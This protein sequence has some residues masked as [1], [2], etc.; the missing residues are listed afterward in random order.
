M[1]VTQNSHTTMGDSLS[2]FR[3]ISLYHHTGF[4]TFVSKII[5]FEHEDKKHYYDHSPLAWR[6][7]DRYGTE[8]CG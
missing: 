4:T 5:I 6:N 7:N 3:G 8:F 1:G 2:V